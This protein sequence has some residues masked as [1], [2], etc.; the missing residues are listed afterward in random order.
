M[1]QRQ[2]PNRTRLIAVAAAAIGAMGLVPVP[3]AQAQPKCVQFGFP[4]DV[5][6]RQ[7]NGWSVTFSSTG[8]TASGPAQA[9]GDSGAKMTGNVSGGI[10][11]RDI[12]LVIQWNEGSR[13]RYTGSVGDDYYMSG[14]SVDEVTPSSRA[15]YR[16]VFPISCLTLADPPKPQPPRE[17]P[18]PADPAP[19]G[20]GPLTDSMSKSVEITDDV[21]VYDAPGG[22][23]K[24]IGVLDG[25]DGQRTGLFGCNPD[26]WCRISFTGGP[27]GKGW[28][29]GD[30]LDRPGG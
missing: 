29:W 8:S 20:R 18:I 14:L 6:L 1:L 12:N 3:A 30:F 19:E 17:G 28:V 4:G 10:E 7:T 22:G 5:Q 2:S 25:G 9:T 15:N 24:V 26:N 11:G 27:D 23:G 21:D 13:G 16:S